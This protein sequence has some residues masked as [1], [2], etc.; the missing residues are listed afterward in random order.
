MTSDKS[1][2]RE[3]SQTRAYEVRTRRRSA[4]GDGLLKALRTVAVGIGLVLYGIYRLEGDYSQRDYLLC[5]LGLPAPFLVGIGIYYWHRARREDA[6]HHR[7]QKAPEL[8]LRLVRDHDDAWVEGRLRCPQPLRP[9]EMSQHCSWYHL[10]IEERRGSGKNSSWVKVKDTTRGT[11]IWITDATREIE[12]DLSKAMVDYPQ[13]TT[14]STGNRRRTLRYLRASG[15]VSA[16]GLARYRADVL[17]KHR[18]EERDRAMEAWVLKHQAA[19]EKEEAQLERLNRKQRLAAAGR[20]I[21]A[22]KRNGRRRGKRP[23]LRPPPKN[24][25]HL[26]SLDDMH[27]VAKNKRLMLT[28]HKHVPLLVTPLPRHHWHDRSE[29]DEL[30]DRTQADVLLGLGI[31]SLVWALGVYLEW[32]AYAFFPG[33]MIGL[34]VMLAIVLPS[35]IINL[36]N[37]FVMYRQRIHTAEADLDADLEMRR[38]LIPNLQAVVKASAKHEASLQQYLVKLRDPSEAAD[39]AIALREAHPEL[40]N[41]QNFALLADDITALEE[42]IAFGRAQL[43]DTINEYDTLIARFPNNLL[44]AVTGF[45][46][47]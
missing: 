23:A 8:P 42:K 33:A 16:C 32:W 3:H 12:V 24:Q 26:Q 35:R 20:A 4:L 27:G 9:P 28:R 13:V 40:A 10:V 18:I 6:L 45:R 29:A 37:R 43:Y 1:G 15:R 2:L 17:G 21:R 25:W 5:G 19:Q 46:A 44:A 38:Q 7:F 14:R 11:S 36:Y 41:N 31:P 47:G 34:T 22:R 30:S 39:T